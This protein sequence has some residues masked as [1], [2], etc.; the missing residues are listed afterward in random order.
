MYILE[1][2]SQMSDTSSRARQNVNIDEELQR[3]IIGLAQNEQYKRYYTYID[4]NFLSIFIDT[5]FQ[6]YDVFVRILYDKHSGNIIFKSNLFDLFNFYEKNEYYDKIVNDIGDKLRALHYDDNIP[7][8]IIQGILNKFTH[9]LYQYNELKFSLRFVRRSPKKTS[10][11]YESNFS[12]DES[13]LKKIYVY[14][15][16][17][18]KTHQL[19]RY[20]DIQD[21]GQFKKIYITVNEFDNNNY[22]NIV[23]EFTEGTMRNP[24]YMI[25]TNVNDIEMKKKL[26]VKITKNLLIKF[27]KDKINIQYLNILLQKIGEHSDIKLSKN[28]MEEL[29]KIAK[30]KIA[31]A[32]LNNSYTPTPV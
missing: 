6:D 2:M 21:H 10:K 20:Y 13:F 32:S 29:I 17:S 3:Y 9:L 7:I 16:I 31:K 5:T 15:T 23:C 11:Q 1:R 4:N 24:E 8:E 19:Y 18:P 30:I 12:I 25:S 27:R 22:M 14:S 26:F 28:D